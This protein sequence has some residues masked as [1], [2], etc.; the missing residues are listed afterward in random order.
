MKTYKLVESLKRGIIAQSIVKTRFTNI[1]S[2]RSGR[3]HWGQL[4]M[5]GII[6]ISFQTPAQQNIAFSGVVPKYTIMHN[7]AG[8]PSDGSASDSQSHPMIFWRGML[9]GTT[10]SGG[11]YDCGTLFKIDPEGQRYQLIWA[12]SA[13]PVS[14][15]VPYQPEDCLPVGILYG[16][17]LGGGDAA[18]GTLFRIV[19]PLPG[20]WGIPPDMLVCFDCTPPSTG[21][22]PEGLVRSGNTLFGTANNDGLYGG[23]TVFKYN[24]DSF[25]YT[26]IT[27]LGAVASDGWEPRTC[28]TSGGLAA[29]DCCRGPVHCTCVI[30]GNVFYG[31]TSGGGANG[32]GTLFRIRMSPDNSLC[33]DYTVLHSFGG[34]L[35]DAGDVDGGNSHTPLVLGNNEIYGTVYVNDPVQA[36]QNTLIFKMNLD[37]SGYSILHVIYN[38]FTTSLTWRNNTLY[39]TTY[40]PNIYAAN[41][42]VF[43]MNIDG[44]GFSIL[45]TFNDGTLKD[46]NGTPIPDGKYPFGPLTFVMGMSGLV[47]HDAA[48]GIADLGGTSGSPNGGVIFGLPVSTYTNTAIPA[49]V[50]WWPG[51]GNANDIVGGHNGVLHGTASYITGK[52]GQ[53]FLFDGNGDIEVADVPS[54]NQ[55]NQLTIEAWVFATSNPSSRQD[56][57]GKEGEY[58]LTSPGNTGTFRAQVTT[59]NGIFYIDGNKPIVDGEWFHVAMTY[60]SGISNL[61][62]YVNGTL[63]ASGTVGGSLVTTTQP[64]RIGSG[65]TNA[66]TGVIDEP[67]IYNRALT[68]IEIESIYDAASD[69]K[70]PPFPLSSCTPAPTNLVSWW[71]AESNA[72]D[73]VG[74]NNGTLFNGTGFA[75]GEVGQAFSFNGGNQAVQIPY[76]P[77]LVSSSYT[78]ETWVEPMSQVTNEDQ[79]ALI[80]GESYGFSQII[81]LPGTTGI[82]VQFQFGDGAG[83][84]YGVASTNE[85]PIGQFTHIAGTW[86]GTTMRLYVNGVLNATSTPGAY[87]ASSGCPF[88]IGGFFS[89]DDG[90]CQ[91]VAQFFNGLIDEVSQYNRSLTASEIESIYDA[92][93]GGK[94]PY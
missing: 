23:G 79:Q 16:T 25:K 88:Y 38:A 51:E 4:V 53:G 37:G 31:T 70:C 24:M 65:A 57:V 72:N 42:T 2:C 3:I 43:K 41:A 12:L 71:Q 76:S 15:L 10:G 18:A 17:S 5:T 73:S 84:W 62:L 9:Y 50:S 90:N 74:G 47:T 34:V 45:H 77:T 1:I 83:G 89:P 55:T 81:A 60:D 82:N 78:M 11:W 91:T 87:P 40:S 39:G 48:Y 59:T 19:E 26:I 54:L 49:L 22:N 33:Y 63:D 13:G 85:I 29:I 30:L 7:F 56:I 27:N 66:F 8:A 86:D 64:V 28:L 35:N 69:G 44:K 32:A 75:S 61:S 58:L 6:L 68:N 20:I 46:E 92:G 80:Y 14:W 21:A 67:T 93:N 94:C 52:V 36:Y